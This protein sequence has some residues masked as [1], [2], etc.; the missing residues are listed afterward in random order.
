MEQV[1]ENWTSLFDYFE[2][3]GQM[4]E[5]Q[6]SKDCFSNQ[7]SAPLKKHRLHYN[8]WDFIEYGDFFNYHNN[9]DSAVKMTCMSFWNL[10][11]NCIQFS[12]KNN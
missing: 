12:Q 3:A 1:V 2:T 6:I 7:S 8:K 9:F 5:I 4:G 10:L 11:N